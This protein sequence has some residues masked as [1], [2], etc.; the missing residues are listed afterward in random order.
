ML[1]QA[2]S[3]AGLS[4][5]DVD[6]VECHGTGTK[7][8]SHRGGGL[9]AVYGTGHSAEQPLL[10]GALKA[11]VGHME[12]ASG[13]AGAAKVL[14]A[15]HAWRASAQPAIAELNPLIPWQALPVRCCNSVRSGRVA[16]APV[17]PGSARSASAAPTRT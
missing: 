6:Y 16:P 9:A 1:R 14:L 10:L 13:L 12:A 11:T 2:L 3:Q 15:L 4:A 5:S 8:G 7:R 17:A